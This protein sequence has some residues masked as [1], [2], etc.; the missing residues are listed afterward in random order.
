[1]NTELIEKIN[2]AN[3]KRRNRIITTAD[4]EMFEEIF[5]ERKDNPEIKT[6]RVYPRNAFVPNSYQYRAEVT[7]IQATRDTDGNWQIGA[8]TV[9]AK[10]SHGQG[11][12]VT[13]NGRSL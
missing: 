9:D 5:N 10:R 2:K 12:R 4:I 8:G 11:P 1:M 6:I 7:I 13:V 3:G